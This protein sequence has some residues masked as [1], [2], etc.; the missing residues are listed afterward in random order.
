MC[1]SDSTLHALKTY[2]VCSPVV[3][4]KDSFIKLRDKK[5]SWRKYMKYVFMHINEFL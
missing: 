4:E 5:L 3:L 1:K 2:I